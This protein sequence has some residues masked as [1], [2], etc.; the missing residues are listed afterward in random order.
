MKRLSWVKML[1]LFVIMLGV[2]ITGCGANTGTSQSSATSNQ[3]ADSAQTVSV[4]HVFG[5]TA[6]PVH[7][8][9]IASYN[10]EDILLS[11]QAPL[12]L[13]VSVG[14]NYYLEDRLKAQ[15]A[16]IL[17]MDSGLANLEAFAE[18]QP[19]LIVASAT[20]DRTTY[21][22]LSLIAPTI[23][24]DREDWKTSIV[25]IG[26]ALDL[27]DQAQQVI[28][29][30]NTQVQQAKKAITTAV[31]SKATIAFVRTTSKDIRLYLPGYK[32]RE[33]KELPGYAGMLY[34][35]LGLLPM[36]LVS[37][38]HTENPDKQNVNLSTEVLPEV[39]ADYVFVTS[40][41][42]GG[43]SEDLQKDQSQF[44]ELQKSPIWQALP[45]VQ[46]KHLYTVNAKY[47]ISTGPIAD[48]FKIK[49]AV[50]QLTSS[51]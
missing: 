20:I 3:Q 51:S 16:S 50:Q 34:N 18:A 27:E 14:E 26:K 24:Y 8:K 47:W 12:V 30:H 2:I 25:K 29:D 11:L 42:A 1:P 9:R 45:A 17:N 36:P 37:Q 15:N 44:A 7:P 22:Q 38:L 19:D 21:D 40:G 39:T 49:D 28:A 4:E 5:T 13:G 32:D 10:L 33:G 35:D 31:G 41:S 48:Q 43:T 6:I 23:V 46:H